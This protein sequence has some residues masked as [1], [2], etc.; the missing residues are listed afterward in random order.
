MELSDTTTR[1][2][3]R[4]QNAGHDQSSPLT[5]N[6]LMKHIFENAPK[7]AGA[8]NHDDSDDDDSN[9]CVGSVLSEVLPQMMF[10][11]GETAEPSV[12][13]TGIIEDI[14]KE[15]VVEMVLSCSRFAKFTDN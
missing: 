5:Y 9:T 7:G 8:T 14:V 13:T 4:R 1:S 11:S 2:H 6:K 3:E 10:V 15:Q 12:E